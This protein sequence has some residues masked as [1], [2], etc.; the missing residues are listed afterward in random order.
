VIFGGGL[1][2]W[3]YNGVDDLATQSVTITA[4]DGDGGV[5][6]AVFNLTVNNVAPTA[7]DP[8]FSLVENSPNGT[9]V[10]S[11]T[12]NDPGADTLTFTITGGSGAA[13]FSIDT[14]GQ[15]TVTDGSL[16]DFEITPVLTLEVEVSDGDGG[17]DTALVTINLINQASISGVVFVDVNENGLFEANEPGVDGITIHLLDQFG[18]PILDGLGDPITA[19]TSNGG[20]YLFD[21]LD[22]GVYQLFE[23]QPSGVSDGAE[24]LGSLG[25]TVVANDQM[26]LT[27]AQTDAYDYAFAEIG[28]QLS[29]GDTATIGFWQ[30][31]NGQ[32]L[33]TAGG[34]QLASWLT[35]N[36]S[37]VFGNTLAGA[38]GSDVASFYRDQLFKQQSKK[39]AGP[40]KVDAQFMAVALA[41]YFTSGILAGQAATAYGFNVTDTGIGTKIVNV[42]TKGAAFGVANGTDQTILQLLQAT[43][44]LTDQPDAQLGFASIY[45]I[46][47]DG[48]ISATEAA[49]RTM[50]NGVFSSINEAGHI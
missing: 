4:S 37:N 28:Q 11:V 31:K 47:G 3:S 9:V 48:V 8:T 40:A 43:D 34:S 30:N 17:T 45:D 10:G 29:S 22:P 12:A 42:G 5:T 44:G 2:S 46:N 27:L 33:I 16:L 19:V 6:N 13:A 26:Q 15:I 35:S 36:F 41:T 21:D 32:A 50:A 39:S 1:W 25:G 20:F 23:T 7:S 14:S 18:N 24:Q 38:S 49:L